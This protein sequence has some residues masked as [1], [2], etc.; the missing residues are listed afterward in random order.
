MEA[1]VE[2]RYAGVVVGSATEILTAA[3]NDSGMFLVV[4]EPLPVGSV[5]K[6]A[7][8]S[9]ARVEKVVEST[10]PRAAG[11]Y[12]RLIAE[13]EASEPWTPQLPEMVP[14]PP[15]R[16]TT[17]PSVPLV[18]P[19]VAEA[20]PSLGENGE[21]RPTIAGPVPPPAA[22]DRPASIVLATP[23]NKVVT[24]TLTGSSS[25]PTN[26]RT[27]PA[28]IVVIPSGSAPPPPARAETD[29]RERRSTIIT[30]VPP[31]A[32]I[33]GV[34]NAKVT[35]E[36]QT[37][38]GRNEPSE[39]PAAASIVISDGEGDEGAVVQAPMANSPSEDV[40]ATPEPETGLDELRPARPL[41]RKTSRRRRNTR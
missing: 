19:R 21:R 31:P 28:T 38:S 29:K 2:I 25:A 6:L 36:L 3:G 8:D 17:N 41:P 13:S 5:V 35:G 27:P 22:P 34:P 15:P 9:W 11:M 37:R 14:L 33:E 7:G 24:G 39:K 23:P 1:P 4:A 10:D 26:R 32:E 16:R 20:R 30:P 18:S 12:V 40:T